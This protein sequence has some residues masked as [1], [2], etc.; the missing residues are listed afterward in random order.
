MESVLNQFKVY[1]RHDNSEYMTKAGDSCKIETRE[2][3]ETS[4]D[5]CACSR[6]IALIR[7]ILTIKGNATFYNGIFIEID[8]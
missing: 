5:R 1:G 3:T 8:K 7:E 4:T 2:Q 6:T